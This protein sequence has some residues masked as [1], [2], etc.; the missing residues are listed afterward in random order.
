MKSNTI[1]KWIA[2]LIITADTIFLLLARYSNPDMPAVRWFINNIPLLI[3][4]F[5]TL[6]VGLRIYRKAH[7]KE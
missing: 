1:I 5:M 3:F 6:A 4:Y 2:Y 7:I